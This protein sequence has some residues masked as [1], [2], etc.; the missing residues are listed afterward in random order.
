MTKEKLEE[1][2]KYAEEIRTEIENGNEEAAYYEN[3]YDELDFFEM[4]DSDFG[5]EEETE[6]ENEESS[7]SFDDDEEE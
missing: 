1:I 5:D 7:L 6:D 2:I 4:A 3:L